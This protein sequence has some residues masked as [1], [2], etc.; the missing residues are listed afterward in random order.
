[1]QPGVRVLDTLS[2]KRYIVPGADGMIPDARPKAV[3]V[4]RPIEATPPQDWGLIASRMTF[5]LGVAV[6]VLGVVL[7]RRR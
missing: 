1:L 5:G 6:L 4:S 3:D 2:N 7:W